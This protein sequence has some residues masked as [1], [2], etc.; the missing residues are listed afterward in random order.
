MHAESS[1]KQIKAI[2]HQKTFRNTTIIKNHPKYI[3][4]INQYDFNIK[5][6]INYYNLNN[7]IYGK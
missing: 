1:A 2:K 4:S 5:A 6:K 7:I 3:E